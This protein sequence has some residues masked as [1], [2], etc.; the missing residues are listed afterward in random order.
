LTLLFLAATG[1]SPSPSKRNTNRLTAKYQ[2]PTL[3]H[4]DFDMGEFGTAIRLIVHLARRFKDSADITEVLRSVIEQSTSDAVVQRMF[5]FA[6]EKTQEVFENPA[7]VDVAA[8][9]TALA[10]RMK[11]RY[12]AGSNEPIYSPSRTFREWQILVYWARIMGRSRRT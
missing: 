8:L 6:T 12:F 2:R 11:A 1:N 10:T 7:F 5:H 3:A 4:D 9:K